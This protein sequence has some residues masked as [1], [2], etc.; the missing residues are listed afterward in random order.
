MRVGDQ[1]RGQTVNVVVMREKKEVTVSVTLDDEE[2]GAVAPPRVKFV[3]D[4]RNEQN[5]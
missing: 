2:R 5:F 3:R 1:R 4:V